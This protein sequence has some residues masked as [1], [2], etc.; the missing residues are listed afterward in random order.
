MIS[1]ANNLNPYITS[2]EKEDEELSESTNHSGEELVQEEAFLIPLE[3]VSYEIL[4][5]KEQ[6]PIK[7]RIVYV[8][9]DV[10]EGEVD[11]QGLK[12][13][14]GIYLYS[15]N[16][17][18]EGFWQNNKIHG[19]GKYLFRAGENYEGDWYEGR[20]EG[21][22]ILKFNQGD[23]YEGEFYKDEFDG[24]GTFFYSNGDKFEGEWKTGK[25]HGQGTLWGKERKIIGEWLEDE[26]QHF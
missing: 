9:D 4:E 22:G 8:N 5:K 25:K 6:I 16:E 10:Y 19:Y 17:K 11:S 14:W 3:Q 7:V 13:G 15:N 2:I 23:R 24:K 26:L 12:E 1:E 21:V 20:K 18:Y